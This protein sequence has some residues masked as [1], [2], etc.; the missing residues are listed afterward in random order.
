[1]VWTIVTQLYF[2]SPLYSSA[3]R[4]L[5]LQR[6]DLLP[7]I[8]ISVGYMFS[9][10]AFN[11]KLV[12]HPSLGNFFET[13]SL[14]VTLIMDR[15]LASACA[16]RLAWSTADSLTALRI[17]TAD[18]MDSEHALVTSLSDELVHT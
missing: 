7:V 15:R 13:S 3:F 9:V 2:A 11:M 14:L 6:I 17:R 16:R 5:F 12:H 8:S 1:M 10:T 18:L 4:C